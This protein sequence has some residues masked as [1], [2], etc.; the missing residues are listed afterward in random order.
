MPFRTLGEESRQ[1]AEAYYRAWLDE[2]DARLRAFAREVEETGGPVVDYSPD[3]LGPLWAWLTERAELVDGL[4]ADAD[5]PGW[6][7]PDPGEQAV[8]VASVW[9]VDGY[10][11][12]LGEVC[13]RHL[14]GVDWTLEVD[15]RRGA[16]NV[17]HHWPV[18]D[19]PGVRHNP[20]VLLRILMRAL[21]RPGRRVATPGELYARWAA[22]NIDAAG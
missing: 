9:R 22:D 2:M 4:P 11:R 18:I 6:L 7:V 3:S 1:A 17:D 15:A 8:D 13:R 20:V 10:A 19:G 5:V 14:T 16:V 21:T 12:Y